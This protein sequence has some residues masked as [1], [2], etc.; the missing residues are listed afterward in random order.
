MSQEKESYRVAISRIRIDRG[1]H[2]EELERGDSC[3]DI[4]AGTLETM[5]RLGQA[6][7]ESQ[8]EELEATADE[9]PVSD[10]QST[11]VDEMG[12]SSAAVEA[13][14]TAGLQNAGEL[15]AFGAENNGLSSI[16]GIGEA[17]EKEIQESLKTLASK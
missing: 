1:D 2:H 15:A 17:T 4:P 6:V 3:D 5:L 12:L 8:F 11:P 9:D 7:P 14:S 10:W 16:K 13:L